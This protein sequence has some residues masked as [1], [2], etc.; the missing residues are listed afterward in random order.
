[1]F[2]D[3]FRFDDPLSWVLFLVYALVFGGLGFI[4]ALFKY[5]DKAALYD[6]QQTY[7]KIQRT[8]YE[9]RLQEVKRQYEELMKQQSKSLTE[10]F[11]RQMT[12][13]RD[14]FE[15][16]T[17]KATQSNSR[18]LFNLNN[19]QMDAIM[20]PLKE[21]IKRMEETMAQNNE[22]TVRMHASLEQNIQQMVAKALALG[23]QADRLSNAL[24]HN[25][26][27]TGNWGELV[28]N[29][30]LESQGLEKGVHFDVQST[31]KDEKGNT[32][33]NEDT[34]QR[35]VPDVVLHLADKR[36]VII[37]SKVS[38]KSFVDYRSASD[39]SERNDAV[40]RLVASLRAHVRELSNKNYQDYIKKP[41]VSAGFVVMFV[42]V[43]SALQLA[44]AES[45]DLWRDAFDKK[46]FIVGAQTLMAALRIIDLTWV[47]VKQERNTLAIL[48]E[49]RKLVDRVQQFYTR[50][51]DLGKKLA[52]AKEA[53]DK[54]TDKVSEG[55]QSI[56]ASGRALEE[57][58]IRGKKQIA[59]E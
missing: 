24:L 14:Q 31:I 3:L 6:S 28:L 44:L 15:N 26:K 7:E 41:R 29:E 56:L 58:G 50:Y 42:P 25:N 21:N 17:N 22:K 47:N 52:D 11:E 54:V 39:D 10:S 19:R 45:P 36:D 9:L 16:I 48:D 1:M 2:F 12:M 8:T 33:R 18:E 55:K 27:T 37:D 35:M 57:L 30:L 49:A 38:L 43:E 5:G 53:Y 13:L 4:I 59:S 32:V 46:V 34:G 51:Q 23:E 40:I 20:N